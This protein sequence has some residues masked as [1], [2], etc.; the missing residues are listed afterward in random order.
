MNVKE[1]LNRIW[2]GQATGKPDRYT[3]EL[4]AAYAALV[5]ARVLP[6][7]LAAPMDRP[8]LIPDETELMPALPLG[9]VL[10][11]ELDLHVPYGTLILILPDARH[12]GAA[13]RFSADLGVMVAESL[14][15][16][17]DHG[18]LPMER[19]TDTLYM[20]AHS[21]ARMARAPQLQRKGVDLPGFMRG[22]GRSL[23]AYWGATQAPLDDRTLFARQDFLWTPQLASYLRTLDAG[24]TA[25]DPVAIPADLIGVDGTGLV[26]G[27]WIAR[28]EAGVRRLLT[29]TGTAWPQM[30]PPKNLMSRFN[31]H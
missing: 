23:A 20:L 29:T 24:F 17:M 31:L 22:L 16:A 12:R 9:D 25:P 15:V 5:P 7:L 14:L 3:R 4:L 8:M 27:E 6:V 1:L 28:L 13:D 11:E 19:E 2:Q 21:A 26:L 18:G 30:A 10:S